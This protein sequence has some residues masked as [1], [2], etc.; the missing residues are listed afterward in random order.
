MTT[1]GT[2][3]ELLAGYLAVHVSPQ[4]LDVAV[5]SVAIHHSAEASTAGPGAIVVGI[6]ISADERPLHVVMQELGSAGARAVVVR[7]CD[8]TV[9]LVGEALASGVALLS[10]PDATTWA[11]V[12]VAL[13]SVLAQASLGAPPP[14]PFESSPGSLFDVAN[15]VADL[16]SAP[17]TFEDLHGRVVAFS[18]QR[19]DIDIQ[20][21][22]TILHGQ[23]PTDHMRMLRERGV[24]TQL[25][26]TGDPIYL[27]P[28]EVGLSGRMGIAVRAGDELLGCIWAVVDG[29]P[30][31]TQEQ[32]LR[33]AAGFVALQWF[34]HR[35]QSDVRAQEDA[36]LVAALVKGGPE[37][38]EA[39][40]KAHLAEGRYRVI[41]VGLDATGNDLTESSRVR[42]RDLLAL[43]LSCHGRH[44]M[45]GV[46]GPTVVAVVPV[47]T[48]GMLS[49]EQI[50]RVLQRLMERTVRDSGPDVRIGVGSIAASI[51]ELPASYAAATQVLAALRR[52]GEPGTIAELEDVWS[53]AF[54]TRLVETMADEPTLSSG[55]LQALVQYDEQH[56]TKHATTLWTYFD[57]FGDIR[58]TAKQL[59][60]HPNSVRY[61]IA[62]L[63]NVAK[64]RLDDPLER[65]AL[66]VQLHALGRR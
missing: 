49:Q 27:E 30:T 9:P 22:A 3:V 16:I 59:G 45:A 54:L 15:F 60:V 29:P 6:G 58:E 40:R 10:V 37:G 41:A 38:Q 34:R 43:H 11:Q 24:Y 61:R 57:N 44:A 26:R 13:S 33:N 65:L 23:M 51:E 52:S 55:P 14:G 31:P 25:I 66:M 50:K 8:V 7:E 18:R 42:Y 17:V 64:I 39:A 36:E 62:Q 4:G 5:G 21:T 32:V 19:G 46:I 56:G 35:L 28:A 63:R 47:R 1:L 20:R 2:V 48:P 53:S 12:V